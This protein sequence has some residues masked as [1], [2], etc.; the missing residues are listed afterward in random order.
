M[1]L[2]KLL[3]TCRGRLS[4]EEV[5]AAVGVAAVSIWRWEN[6]KDLPRLQ[7]L[8]RFLRAVDAAPEHRLMTW[9]LVDGS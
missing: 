2:G 4:R 1:T 6:D 5:A 3:L 7:H 8:A 9:N